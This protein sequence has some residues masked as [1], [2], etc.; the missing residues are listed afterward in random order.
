MCTLP[1]EAL[2]DPDDVGRIVTRRHEV[3]HAHRALVRL[4]RRLEHERVLEVAARRRAAGRGCEQPAAVVL[5]AE[6]RGEAGTGV[7]AGEAEPVDRAAAVDERRR[8]EVADQR[9]VLDPRHR[10]PQRFSIS[11]PNGG[12][13]F[14]TA[15]LNAASYSSAASSSSVAGEAVAHVGERLRR[16]LDD[17]DVVA[18]ARLRLVARRAVVLQLGGPAL[19][20]QLGL[21]L[22]ED[23][24]LARDHVG[25]A[26]AE[27]HA[28][29]P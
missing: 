20:D 2:D 26:A 6:Q 15:R 9:V 16:G 22:G 3:E 19:C 7:E 1:R 24:E 17:V 4:P 11:S 10:R 13:R 29:S 14:F 28:I 23:V 25:E 5:V 12:Q 27:D 18:V 21:V 8:L